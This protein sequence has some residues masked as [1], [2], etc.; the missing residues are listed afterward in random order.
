MK[1]KFW[2][3]E[4]EFDFREPLPATGNDP[5]TAFGPAPGEQLGL[6]M[7]RTEGLGGT[8]PLDPYQGNSQATD[9][10]QDVIRG[11]QDY[12]RELPSAQP[13]LAQ[14]SLQAPGETVAKDLEII[15]SKLDAIKAMVES[16]NQRLEHLER[17]SRD[18]Y[19]KW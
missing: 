10:G 9:F 12:L 19:K 8:G 17:N 11:K 13:R 14:T 18:A 1:L 16:V 2:K 7:D 4:P 6:G 5:L 15:S 3:K